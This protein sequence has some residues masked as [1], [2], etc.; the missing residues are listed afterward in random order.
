MKRM[1]LTEPVLSLTL[2]IGASGAGGISGAAFAAEPAARD[3]VKLDRTL[4]SGNQE[5]PK[6]LYILPWESKESRPAIDYTLPPYNDG[7]MQRVDPASHTRQLNQLEG[8]RTQIT[9]H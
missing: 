6:V 4:V 5:L 3:R 1:N 7:I 2:L 8:L 9:S